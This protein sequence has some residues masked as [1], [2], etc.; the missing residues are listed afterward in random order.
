[1][2]NGTEH[3]YQ[4]DSLNR[5]RL[6][7]LRDGTANLL[8]EYEY[9]LKISGHRSWIVESTGRTLRLMK[10]SG[11]EGIQKKRLPSI[12]NAEVSPFNLSGVVLIFFL[13]R[14]QC[15]RAW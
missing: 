8:H 12:M 10:E 7:D 13:R 14:P 2:G 6:L 1:M 5:L 15:S 11:I 4:Y 3:R 9:N